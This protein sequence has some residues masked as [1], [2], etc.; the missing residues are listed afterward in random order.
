MWRGLS[1]KSPYHTA[2]EVFLPRHISFYTSSRYRGIMKKLLAIS[3]VAIIVLGLIS[4]TPFQH[5]FAVSKTQKKIDKLIS[6]KLPNKDWTKI[7]ALNITLT[8][9]P[10]DVI[11]VYNKT[12]TTPPPPNPTPTGSCAIPDVNHSKFLRVAVTGD[13]KTNGKEFQVIHDCHV[14]VNIVPGDLWYTSTCNE[15]L[16]AVEKLGWTKNNTDLGVGNHDSDGACIRNWMGQTSTYHQIFFTDKL[17]VTT[18]NGNTDL[19]CTS[20]QYQ[21]LKPKIE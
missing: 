12:G 21:A 20:A 17:A 14:D 16:S 15:W 10:H 11:K 1:F 18:L 3:I 13:T 4:A 6:S 9:T 7:Q 5:T 19:K 2:L 8:T